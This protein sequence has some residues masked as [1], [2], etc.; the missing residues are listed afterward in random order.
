MD[1]A[2]NDCAHGRRGVTLIEASL[3]IAVLGILL[4]SV[5]P[6]GSVTDEWSLARAAR[7]TEGVLTRARLT[8]ISRRHTLRVRAGTGFSLETVD[9]AGTIVSRVDLSA[10]GIRAIDSLR[11]RPA[12]LRYNPRGQGS[13][14]SVYLFRG[15]RGIR[16][17]SN[18]VGRI[19]RHGFRF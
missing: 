15:R 2:S 10:S 7:L 5:I 13:A 18:F 4:V 12:T 16:V 1:Q 17:V 19:R 14:G 3:A 9:Q 11:I 6:A 8:A